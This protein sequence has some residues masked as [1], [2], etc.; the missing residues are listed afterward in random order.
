MGLGPTQ[1]KDVLMAL[2]CLLGGVDSTVPGSALE[3]G[4]SGAG[5]VSGRPQSALHPS[6]PVAHIVHGSLI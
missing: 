3:N 6:A 2:V 4:R 1:K 5:M